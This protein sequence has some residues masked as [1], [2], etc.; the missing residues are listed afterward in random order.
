MQDKKPSSLDGNVN[1]LVAMQQA[2]SSLD[3]NVIILVAMQEAIFTGW[4]C[5][6]SS[7]NAR[8]HLHWMAMS[9]F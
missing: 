7:C 2:L 3:G 4:Q 6:H 8:S 1:I 9:T 5:Q